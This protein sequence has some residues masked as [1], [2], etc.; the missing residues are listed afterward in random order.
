MNTAQTTLPVVTAG[1]TFDNIAQ[2]LIDEQM[3]SD[4]NHLLEVVESAAIVNL[5]HIDRDDNPHKVTKAQ[6]GL[7]NVDNTSDLDKPLSNATASVI[8]TLGNVTIS[9][10]TSLRNDTVSEITALKTENKSIQSA[11]QTLDQTNQQK[12]QDTLTLLDS[13]ITEVKRLITALDNK[14]ISATA[15]LKTL[16]AQADT[17]IKNEITTA[18][19][20][21][22]TQLQANIN[23]KAPLDH[24]H[25]SVYAKIGTLG[26]TDGSVKTN[27][28]ANNAITSAKIADNTIVNGDI[29]NTTITGDKLVN[30]TITAAK[31]ADNTITANQLAPNSVGRDELGVTYAKGVAYTDMN[32]LFTVFGLQK[33]VTTAQLVKKMSTNMIESR[34]AFFQTGYVGNDYISDLPVNPAFI[35]IIYLDG[36]GLVLEARAPGNKALWVGATNGNN[37]TGWTKVRG[38]DGLI[39]PDSINMGNLM[40]MMFRIGSITA[41]STSGI[42]TWGLL[43]GNEVLQSNGSYFNIRWT[44]NDPNHNAP[45]FV[46]VNSGGT[47]PSSSADRILACKLQ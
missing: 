33:P 12:H 15:T 26:L 3:A 2:K 40:G 24:N 47:M 7:G 36:N 25:D 18:Y 39:Y 23:S 29:A 4:I 41:G 20:T 43:D 44:K 22:N 27:H 38:E 8:A 13:K 16:F 17:E 42:G 10:I 14:I 19:Q 45:T 9:A 21:N 46:W 5:E 11:V 28:I 1:N 30:K 37:F 32:D 31:I 34:K 35:T 6:V